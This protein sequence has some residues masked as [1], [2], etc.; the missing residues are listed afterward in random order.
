MTEK[1]S[2]IREIYY[3][4]NW[5][6]YKKNL[7][8]LNEKKMQKAKILFK[9]LKELSESDREILAAKYDRP[10]K[11]S[12]PT[13]VHPTDKDVADSLDMPVKEYSEKRRLAQHNLKE[14]LIKQNLEESNE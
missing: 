10:T 11:W 4:N 8:N 5:F 7:K 3:L 2:H 12:G 1:H 14:T 6:R 13:K 9:A